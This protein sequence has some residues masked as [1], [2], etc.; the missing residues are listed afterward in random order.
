MCTAYELGKRGGTFPDR[1]GAA[2]I[3]EL[4]GI[5]RTR[6]LRPT[7]E[8]PVIV[9]GGDMEMMRWGFCRPFSNAIVNARQDKLEGGMWRGAMEGRRCLIPVAAYYEWSGPKGSK[10]THRFTRPD[11]GWLWIAGIWEENMELGNC[12]SM[13]TTMANAVARDIHGRMPAV[14]G[15]GE[16]GKFLDGEMWEFDPGLDGLVVNDAPN[17]LSKGRAVQGELF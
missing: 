11:E 13:I 15:A 17:P 3:A 4:I 1:A 7:L 12:F 16:I 14:L 5:E 10:R 9:E 2:A 8:A 6:L